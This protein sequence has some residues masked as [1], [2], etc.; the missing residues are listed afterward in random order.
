MTMNTDTFRFSM[1]HFGQVTERQFN[2][3]VVKKTRWF[4]R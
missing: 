4:N 3:M 2:F 1:P